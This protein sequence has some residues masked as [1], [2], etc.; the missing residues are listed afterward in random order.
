MG[1]RKPKVDVCLRHFFWPELCLCL[2]RHMDTECQSAADS[3][4][5][6]SQ[7]YREA[8]YWHRVTDR[9]YRERRLVRAQMKAQ[10]LL[11]AE[12]GPSFS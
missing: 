1:G 10:R 6:L 9:N 8:E 2:R 5:T 4:P 7:D 3:V 12:S 11:L